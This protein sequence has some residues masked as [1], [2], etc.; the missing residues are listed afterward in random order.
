[1]RKLLTSELDRVCG[2]VLARRASAV[3]SVSPAIG[4]LPPSSFGGIG[5]GG[6]LYWTNW[7]S[8]NSGAFGNSSGS[9]TSSDYNL[10][11]LP[12]ASTDNGDILFQV[13]EGNGFG[14]LTA[15]SSGVNGGIPTPIGESRLTD[16]GDQLR[17]QINVSNV[18]FGNMTISA[19]VGVSTPN[20]H[21]Y[22]EGADVSIHF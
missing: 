2:G 21:N 15:Q 4:I 18:H 9:S 10:F 11:N 6:G 7:S 5:D 20:G 8:N 13:T 16:S 3:D 19:N 12:I 1:M 22:T 14:T 17:A